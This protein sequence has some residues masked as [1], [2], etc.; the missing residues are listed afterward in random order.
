M[1][2]QYTQPVEVQYTQPVEVQYTQPVEVQ[3]VQP[4]EARQ[5]PPENRRSSQPQLPP[6][7][8]R[9][10]SVRLVEQ[11]VAIPIDRIIEI[12]TEKY[13]DRCVSARFL[14]LRTMRREEP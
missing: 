5:A 9:P 10:P 4:V 6:P 11:E 3:Y 7:A 12:P 14:R 13:I 2:V 1:Q 8:P